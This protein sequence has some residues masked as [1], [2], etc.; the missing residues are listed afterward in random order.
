MNVLI[1]LFSLIWL[2]NV[3]PI[4]MTTGAYSDRVSHLPEIPYKVVTNVVVTEIPVFVQAPLEYNELEN[5]VNVIRQSHGLPKLEVNECLREQAKIRANDIKSTWS[6]YRP[7]GEHSSELTKWCVDWEGKNMISVG[8]NLAKDFPTA[9]Q[10]MDAWMDSPS[11][12]E[13]ILESKYSY[14]GIFR[15]ENYVAMEVSN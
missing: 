11:H 12:K 14:I 5:N 4:T 6:H 9:S 2:F 8:E 3:Q 7:D 1:T 15:E 13:L 10:I